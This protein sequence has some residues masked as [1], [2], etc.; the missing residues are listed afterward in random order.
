[1]KWMENK[2]AE[3]EIHRLWDLFLT[4]AAT[5]SPLVTKDLFS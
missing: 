4:M 2:R 1:M 5:A 3:P